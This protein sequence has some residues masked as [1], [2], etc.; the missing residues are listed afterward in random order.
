MRLRKQFLA[1]YGH[2]GHVESLIDDD[3]VAE[4]VASRDDLTDKQIDKLVNSDDEYTHAV[5]ARNPR[6]SPEHFDKLVT[7]SHF[8]VR[9]ALASNTSI[10]DHHLDK[11]RNDPKLVVRWNA[12][13]NREENHG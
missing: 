13:M 2:S 11:L 7:H 3:D 8:A 6:L 5:I 12:M 9:S 4:Y 1:T 10:P